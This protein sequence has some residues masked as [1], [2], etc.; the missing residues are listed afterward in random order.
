MSITH[1]LILSLRKKKPQRGGGACDLRCL[2]HLLVAHGVRAAGF[3]RTSAA[4]TG[5]WWHHHHHRHCGSCPETSDV[6]RVAAQPAMLIATVV[7]ASAPVVDSELACAYHSSKLVAQRC[8]LLLLLWLLMLSL[9]SLLL[10]LR[11]LLF[12]HFGVLR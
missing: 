5:S 2:Q 4:A 11:A 1:K 8:L 3:V 10:L 12:A 6:W 7:A 9:V